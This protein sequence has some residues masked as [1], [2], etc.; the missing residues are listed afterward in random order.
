M[1]SAIQVTTSE[2]QIVPARVRQLLIVQNVSD[3]DIFVQF[4][5]AP[6]TLTAANGLLLAAGKSIGFSSDGISSFRNNRV[7]AIHGG[8]G[9]KEVRVVE[10]V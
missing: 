7:S 8:A 2:T 5:E 1:I 4:T 3:T 10:V 6:G 9:D